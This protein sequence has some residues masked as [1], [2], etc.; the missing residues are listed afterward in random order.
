MKVIPLAFILQAV[1]DGLINCFVP[2]MNLGIINEE[3][4]MGR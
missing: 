3:F 1:Q 2:E 4:D